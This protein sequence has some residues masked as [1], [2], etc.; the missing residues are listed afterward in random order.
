MLPLVALLIYSISRNDRSVHVRSRQ[1]QR[2]TEHVSHGSRAKKRHFLTFFSVKPGKH[3][4]RVMKLL[5]GH[6]GFYAFSEA[7]STSNP[8]IVYFGLNS[9]TEWF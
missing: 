8:G 3:E 4:N 1:K 2:E 9:M 6:R 5:L 7:F